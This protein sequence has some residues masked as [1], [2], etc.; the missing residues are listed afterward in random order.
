MNN[1]NI[2]ETK[3]MD[4]LLHLASRRGHLEMVK[5]FVEHGADVN[6]RNRLGETPIF[7]ACR[8]NHI[9]V[10]HYLIEHGTEV[11]VC[12]W[13]RGLRLFTMRVSVDLLSF[14]NCL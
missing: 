4:S 6:I 12:G 3:L 2:Q 14:W 1:I 8:N 9:D 10:V 13:K 7:L 5:L 11:R